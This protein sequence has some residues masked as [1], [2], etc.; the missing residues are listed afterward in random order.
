MARS[1][2]ID[3]I[4]ETMTRFPMRAA[5]PVTEDEPEAKPA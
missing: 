4:G 5:A 3:K 1:K 2:L